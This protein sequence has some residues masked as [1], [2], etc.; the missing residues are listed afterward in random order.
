M[1]SKKTARHMG[2]GDAPRG[3][4]SHGDHR[5]SRRSSAT[6]RKLGYGGM[7]CRYQFVTGWRLASCRLA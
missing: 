6:M 4:G 3:Q 7:T 2:N 5:H 1:P